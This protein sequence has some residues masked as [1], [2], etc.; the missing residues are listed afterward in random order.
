MMHLQVREKTV[1]L[2]GWIGRRRKLLPA[3]SDLL[4]KAGGLLGLLLVR[5]LFLIRFSL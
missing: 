5:V 1:A 4:L 3:H 2:E